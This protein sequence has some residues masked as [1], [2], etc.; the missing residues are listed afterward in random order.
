MID[1]LGEDT[2]NNNNKRIIW[3]GKVFNANED[4]STID[5]FSRTLSAKI[6]KDSTKKE[7][8]G[9]GYY[10]LSLYNLNYNESFLFE[11]DSDQYI[12]TEKYPNFYTDSVVVVIN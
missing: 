10:Y 9:F 7:I 12:N 3:Y 1:S 2:Y 6:Y 11:M 4:Q 5:R 8:I